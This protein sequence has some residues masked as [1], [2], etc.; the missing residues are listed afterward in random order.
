M[1]RIPT[2]RNGDPTNINRIRIE[3]T[4]YTHSLLES[5]TTTAEQLIGYEEHGIMQVTSNTRFPQP[6]S[7]RDAR[8]I[9][10]LWGPIVV[11]PVLKTNTVFLVG[12]PSNLANAGHAYKD[13]PQKTVSRGLRI[14]QA[15]FTQ[16]LDPKALFK[17]PA[18]IRLLLSD[19][20]Q[21]RRLLGVPAI[22]WKPK[23][24]FIASLDK[25][26]DNLRTKLRQVEPDAPKL[27]NEAPEDNVQVVT[28]PKPHPRPL[29]ELNW[30]LS[31]RLRSS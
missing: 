17:T 3:A 24:H 8:N 21:E 2:I 5:M 4:T 18:E 27:R 14:P 22:N 25:L 15:D 23:K 1:G 7:I 29:H 16:L 19:T 6:R 20:K 9:G 10:G 31:S 28:P 30:H 26:I 13:L 11:V 12:E